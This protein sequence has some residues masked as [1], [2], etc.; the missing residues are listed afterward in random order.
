MTFSIVAWDQEER[1]W[2]VAVASKF[3]AAGSVVSWAQAGVG[4]IATQA[5]AN[6]TYGPRGLD[7]LA[8][9]TADEVVAELTGS[10]PE[11][12]QRQLGVV[13][14]NGRAAAFTGAECFDWAGSKIG[15]G[16]TCQGN[17]LTGPEVVE[18]MAAAFESTSGDLA[19]RLLMAMSAGD[20]VGGDRRGKQSAAM[21][22]TREGGGYLGGTD[23]ALDLRVDDHPEPVAELGRVIEVHRLLFPNPRDLDF[24]DIDDS[25]AGRMA[26][27]LSAAG[28]ETNSPAYDESLRKALFSWMGNENLEMRWSDDPVVDRTVLGLLLGED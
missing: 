16:Y 9:K 12:T 18:N 15:D 25:L 1:E 21:L 14:R 3:L 2:G 26:V 23:V 28:F 17:I 11:S 13:D 24:V 7:L 22:I 6:V 27:A 19:A 8:A 5:Y 20:A 10:D 4:A